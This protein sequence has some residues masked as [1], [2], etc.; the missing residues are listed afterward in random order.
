MLTRPAN[1]RCMVTAAAT[2]A[3]SLEVAEVDEDLVDRLARPDH[4]VDT[5]TPVG[6]ETS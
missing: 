4:L 6:S 5:P 3:S 2:A 1:V